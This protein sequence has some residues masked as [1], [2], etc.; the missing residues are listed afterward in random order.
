MK[1][2]QFQV[3][4]IHIG[5][6]PV[7]VDGLCRIRCC[8]GDNG[9]AHLFAMCDECEA[10]DGESPIRPRLRNFQMLGIRCAPFATRACMENNHIGRELRI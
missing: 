8:E 4:W 1:Q 6:C 7:C 5:E 10:R 9:I 3:P 2:D